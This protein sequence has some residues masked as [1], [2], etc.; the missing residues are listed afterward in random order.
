MLTLMIISAHEYIGEDKPAMSSSAM[1][2]IIVAVCICTLLALL[3]LM[4][5]IVR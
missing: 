3:V 2:G 1:I 5:L 4:I